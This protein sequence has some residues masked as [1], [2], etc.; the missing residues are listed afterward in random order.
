M[1]RRTGLPGGQVRT[2]LP[3][4]FLYAR[5]GS[6]LTGKTCPNLSAIRNLSAHPWR[7]GF[8]DDDAENLL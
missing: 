4:K 7:S 1:G 5:A 2:G 8:G 3:R 6:L